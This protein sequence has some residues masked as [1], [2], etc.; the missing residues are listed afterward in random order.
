MACTT[1]TIDDQTRSRG[2]K[3]SR[4]GEAPISLIGGESRAYK[5]QVGVLAKS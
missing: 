1:G 3:Q 2:F 5:L 4:G